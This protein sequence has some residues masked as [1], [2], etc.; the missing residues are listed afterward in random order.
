[1]SDRSSQSGAQYLLLTRLADE[2]AARYRAGERP[3][4]Q[5]YID[6]YPELAD[7]IRELLPAMVEIEQV[8]EDQQGA[9]HPVAEPDSRAP[10]Q[11]GDF[12]IIREVG[13]GGMG[14]V[15]EA[16][17][18]SLGR[19]V[20]LKV[21]PRSMI[22]DAQARRRFEREAKSAARLHHTNIVPVFG[23]GEH[24]GMP[25][26][27]MQFIQGLGLDEVLE[28]LKRL[29]RDNT[30]AETPTVGERRVFRR[31][32]SAVQVAH[33]LL[34]G[35]YQWVDGKSD[36]RTAPPTIDAACDEDP[37]SD[38]ARCT[39]P[40]DSFALS[41]SSVVLP[42]PGR[43]LSKSKRRKP[44]YW[45][46]VA[47]IG[48]QVANALEYA[49]KQGIRHRDVKP[50]NLLLDTHGTVWVTDFGLAKAED[51]QN[52]THTGD[53]LGT[54]R[55]MP[56]E[57]FE[58]KTDARS[59]VYSLGL[60]LYEMLAFRP[61]FDETD[62]RRLIKQVTDEEPPRLGKLN[63]QVP[64]DL[65]TIVLKAIDKDAKARYASAG[66]LSDDLERFIDDEPIK[67]RKV[68][69]AERLWRWCRRHPA[70]A[71]LTTTVTLLLLILTVG[72]TIA[73]GRLG[74]LAEREHDLRTE[75][76]KRN[77]ELARQDYSHRVALAFH[78]W[79]GHQ[80]LPATALLEGCSDER[81]GWEWAYCHRLCNL[82]LLTLPVAEGKG[83]PSEPGAGLTFSPDG[84]QLAVLGA[85]G[86]L[87]L[88]DSATD[89]VVGTQSFPFA[90]DTTCGNCLA[91]HADGRRL[92]VG[93]DDGA[94][95]LFDA[96]SGQVRAL[97]GHARAVRGVAVGRR[98]QRVASAGSDGT[99]R[100]WDLK[101]GD[102][103]PL[104]ISSHPRGVVSVALSP[105]EDLLASAGNGSAVE[106]WDAATG[107]HLG[108]FDGHEQI[109]YGV[110]FS[111][112]G[113]RLASASWDK[114]IRLWDVA[115][116]QH[117]MT[118]YGHTSFAR[119]VAFTPDGHRLVSV[120][121]DKSVRVWDAHDG[122]AL[123]S[124]AGHTS[125]AVLAA[126]HPDGR[127]VATT[128]W[129]GTVKLWD[130]TSNPEVLTLRHHG[131]V[132]A[133]ALAADSLTLATASG[134]RFQPSGHTVSLWD[135][136]TGRN[137]LELPHEG[138]TVDALALSPDGRRLVTGGTGRIVT[139]YD[140][141]TGQEGGK[142]AGHT[143]SVR[144]VVFDPK[145]KRIASGSL[146]GSVR[147]WDSATLRELLA[148]GLHGGPVHAVA[149]SPDGESIASASADR[150][151]K[152][153]RAA[154]GAVT[155]TLPYSP[156]ALPP[157]TWGANLLAFRPDGARLVATCGGDADPL[158][159]VVWDLALRREIVT[160]RGHAFPPTAVAFSPDGKR[161]ISGSA[162]QTVKLWDAET[163]AELFTL[164]GHGGNVL[165]LAISAD[166]HKIVS[167]GIDN[168]AK[169]WDATPQR[170]AINR[171]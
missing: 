151:I 169:I 51:Q 65:E 44:T 59:D 79:Q 72:A 15:Y 167:G 164:R 33:S 135:A 132:A 88:W 11:V 155:A 141:R 38:S 160:L 19:H 96:A 94:V 147:V 144:A 130:I 49:H 124:L 8:K 153:W 154:T 152:V 97:A 113:R 158:T 140:A 7:D 24:D 71:L 120:G 58:G 108:T 18:V 46:S 78:D 48:M 32:T 27:V 55:Y 161:I 17:Q 73:A 89:R 54:L 168:T 20:A 10:E 106:L 127:R 116:R 5:H 166:G 62:R 68:R 16:E 136:A 82:D 146:D 126:V 28:E 36:E 87:T 125:V 157:L 149:F 21:L 52:L 123:F 25:Y 57:A 31:E 84:R 41:S 145:G 101:C 129:D 99:V 100:I 107:R 53:I 74:R 30:K 165:C 137:R 138:E 142:L 9:T 117:V 110:T 83:S 159:L 70:V 121:E 143:D 131:W 47:T 171:R 163:G 61:A 98:G 86:H 128:S 6:R 95:R 26:Y 93:C 162:D 139:V 60:T 91:Y 104:T 13:K 112:D 150:T 156:P 35:E 14:I 50:S 111:P 115:A 81:R 75:A 37:R 170:E 2:F 23:V 102:A 56:P 133:I 64:Q 119:A 12:R 85:G 22:V 42:G 76:E 63:R 66:E 122:R 43:A 92:V 148:F 105:D 3:S 109:V 69:Q 114:T 80:V 77:D 34:T 45:Q 134:N 67:A 90:F 40:S 103:A 4:L 29:H 118:L 39:D 1:V